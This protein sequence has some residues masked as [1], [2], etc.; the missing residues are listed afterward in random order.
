MSISII[1][2]YLLLISLFS[3]SDSYGVQC[4][5]PPASQYVGE[6]GGQH[7]L[8]KFP[9]VPAAINM[10]SVN[11]WKCEIKYQNLV[12]L[13]FRGVAPRNTLACI[14]SSPYQ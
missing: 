12:S 5:Y 3:A 7:Q 9:G 11:T 8:H 6:G 13:Y 10:L 2:D 1:F 14:K 4:P